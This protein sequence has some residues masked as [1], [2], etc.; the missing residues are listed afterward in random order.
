MYN[1]ILINIVNPDP[2]EEFS[3]SENFLNSSFN[4]NIKN[5]ISTLNNDNIFT[6]ETINSPNPQDFSLG[7]FVIMSSFHDLNKHKCDIDE[8]ILHDSELKCSNIRR[9]KALSKKMMQTKI[10][11]TSRD[12]S[13]NYSVKKIDKD[14]SFISNPLD[15]KLNKSYDLFKNTSDD[16]FIKDFPNTN[17]DNNNYF[18][19]RRESSVNSKNLIKFNEFATC[20]KKIILNLNNR[21]K[22]SQTSEYKISDDTNNFENLFDF[23]NNKVEGFQNEMMDYLTKSKLELEE[24][25]KKFYTKIIKISTDK[26]RR[27]SQVYSGNSNNKNYLNKNSK[28]SNNFDNPF[29]KNNLQ[30][31]NSYEITPIINNYDNILSNEF[32]Y[33]SFKDDFFKS[34]KFPSEN[35]FNLKNNFSGNLHNKNFRLFNKG[36]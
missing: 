17:N 35:S 26:A 18:D 5:T 34:N 11:E 20:E 32:S 24:L 19:S 16:S 6:R 8:I 3:E 25:Y 15:N 36:M 30:N 4:N 22:D 28:S 1:T 2:I 23:I 14:F 29:T 31:I 13:L 10:N 21:R 27:I 9:K 12:N 33:D 7:E